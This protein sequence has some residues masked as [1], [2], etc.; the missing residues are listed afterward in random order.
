MKTLITI[1]LC[2]ILSFV[3]V[4]AYS[5][6]INQSPPSPG[7]QIFS[8]SFPSANVG[9][10]C[11]YGEFFMKTTNGGQNWIDLSLG[12]TGD[13]LN[14]VWFLNETTGFM[15]STN[16]SLLYS[17]NGGLD[18]INYLYLGN[19]GQDL[20]FLNSQT[21][22]ASSYNRLY[23][24]TNAGIN[25][26]LVIN[27]AVPDMFFTSENTGWK[28]SYSSGSS[29]VMKTTNGCQS[30]E[31]K[32]TTTDFR[33]VY[34]IDFINENTGWI[35]GYR[36]YI[37]KTTDGGETWTVQRD[38]GGQGLYTIC[39]I[40]PNIG[41]ASGDNGSVVSTSD[42]GT[43]WTETNLPASRYSKIEFINQNTGWMVGSHGVV[44]KTTNAAGLTFANPIST[45]ADGFE[46][47]QNYPNPFN[48][49]TTIEFSVP[50]SD[51][52]TLKI[53]DMNGKEVATLVN[54]NLNSG[55]YNVEWNGL[56]NSSGIYF[57]K[58]VSG[59]FTA[60]KKMLML[61]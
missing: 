26:S 58:L 31:T 32:H 8:C 39:F 40:N 54:E 28:T 19:Q 42:G 46:L 14:A 30:W 35:C 23:K 7:H 61:K 34:A 51:F 6:W 10:I 17:T 21:G 41:F 1:L 45:V 9:Y 18:W 33:V 11:G 37:A 59:S 27:A 2:F 5:Q 12:F 48:P 44:R 24:T 16:D 50:N 60:V 3:S 15:T 22:W 47:K 20:F 43:T 4:N 52:Y 36:G 13:N 25:W 56:N 49:S 29:Q 57:Y 55:S 53:Y 38:T